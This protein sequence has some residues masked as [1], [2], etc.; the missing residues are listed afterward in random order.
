MEAQGA[1]VDYGLLH[2]I[3]KR[4]NI[5]LVLHGTSGISDNDLA[6]LSKTKLSKVN[7]NTSIRKIFGDTLRNEYEKN[8]VAYDRVELFEKPLRAITDKAIHYMKLLG[9]SAHEG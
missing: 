6:K 7:I 3:E 8:A 1:T 2:K 4:V 9:F 5:P